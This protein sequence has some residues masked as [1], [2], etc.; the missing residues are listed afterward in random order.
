[1]MF[2][3]GP[4]V[5]KDYHIDEG[6]EVNRVVSAS[7]S[8]HLQSCCKLLCSLSNILFLLVLPFLLFKSFVLL[9]HV[10]LK[11]GFHVKMIPPSLISVF[12]FFVFY[13]N[14]YQTHRN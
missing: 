8:V 2:V 12:F 14:K 7:H 10:I 1:M 6:E 4:N 13:D 3:G 11:N 9:L 5:R